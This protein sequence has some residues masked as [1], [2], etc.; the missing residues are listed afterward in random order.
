MRD[1]LLA[2]W[3]DGPYNLLDASRFAA[4]P[5]K[6]QGVVPVGYAAF[7]FAVGSPAAPSPDVACLGHQL[8]CLPWHLV[9]RQAVGAAWFAFLR[10]KTAILTAVAV[11]LVPFS[12]W[13]I[14]RHAIGHAVSR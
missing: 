3:W 10:S 11:L 13:W 6:D 8:G 9:R 4:W 5:F 12:F 2:S 7:A 1:G 14:R